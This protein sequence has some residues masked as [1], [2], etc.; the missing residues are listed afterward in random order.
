MGNHAYNWNTCNV[1]VIGAVQDLWVLMIEKWR[2]Q[3]PVTRLVYICALGPWLSLGG[4]SKL[5]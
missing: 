2:E 4:S 1:K 5:D 3:M